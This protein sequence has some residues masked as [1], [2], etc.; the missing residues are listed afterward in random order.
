MPDAT[1]PALLY[2][3]SVMSLS[4]GIGTPNLPVR[5][6]QAEQNPKLVIQNLRA[7]SSKMHGQLIVTCLKRIG[8]WNWIHHVARRG[9]R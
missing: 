8:V 5:R 6:R 2:L 4:G 3:V 1:D 9:D 7:C